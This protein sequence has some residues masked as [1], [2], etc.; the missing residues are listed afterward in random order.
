MPLNLNEKVMLL[1]NFYQ[2]YVVITLQAVD[3]RG[4]DTAH[5]HSFVVKIGDGVALFDINDLL[6]TL[7]GT[8]MES[9]HLDLESKYAPWTYTSVESGFRKINSIYCTM[10]RYAARGSS[11]IPPAPERGAPQPAAMERAAS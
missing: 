7:V 1:E 4:E 5:F 11:S 9:L 2:E 6:D 8:S 3:A 10:S